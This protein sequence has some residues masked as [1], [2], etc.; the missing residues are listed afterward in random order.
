MN[1][2][3]YKKTINEI[4]RFAEENDKKISRFSVVDILQMEYPDIE[5]PE[6]GQICQA[7]QSNGVQITED[8]DENYSAEVVDPIDFYP[9]NVNI[10]QVN[11]T[12]ATVMDRLCYDEFKLKPVYQRKGGLWSDEK[13]LNVAGHRLPPNSLPSSHRNKMP[14]AES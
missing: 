12:V 5:E 2:Q 6:I 13:Q 14:A 10:S 7:V 9:A 11:L 3:R 8:S 4:C 1:D